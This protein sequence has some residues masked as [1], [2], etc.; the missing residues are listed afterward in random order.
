MRR[1]GRDIGGNIEITEGKQR[2]RVA[3][4]VFNQELDAALNAFIE[5]N[6]VI[7]MPANRYHQKQVG[8][9][10]SWRP[11]TGL[12]HSGL[13]MLLE[14][15]KGWYVEELSQVRKK[16]PALEYEIVVTEGGPADVIVE[17]VPAFPLKAS[18]ELR[19][20]ISIGDGEPQWIM[21]EMGE[22]GGQPWTDNVLESRMVGT[23]EL[24]L[25]P[26]TYPFKLW[27]TDPSVNVDQITIDFGGLEPSYVGSPSTKISRDRQ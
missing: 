20:A 9:A 7:S 26:G 5:T 10:A 23:G 15:M 27:G 6:G 24:N 18:Q 17:A 2:Y 11:V 12:G 13:A 4:S 19:C 3:V 21:F 8:R 1:P 16:S 14:P 25:D 22:P